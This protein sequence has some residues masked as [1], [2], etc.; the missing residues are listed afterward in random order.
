MSDF[1]PDQEKREPIEQKPLQPP[2]NPPE[3]IVPDA[4]PAQDDELDVVEEA[5]E[6]L[7]PASDPPGWISSNR[8]KNAQN[9]NW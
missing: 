7:F 9:Q 5:S 8:R 6:E 2:T 4:D 3:L 1:H